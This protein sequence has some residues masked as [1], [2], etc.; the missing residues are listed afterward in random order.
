MNP[1]AIYDLSRLKMDI[2]V[3]KSVVITNIRK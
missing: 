1:E 2:F 3:N